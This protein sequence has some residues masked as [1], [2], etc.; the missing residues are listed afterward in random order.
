MQCNSELHCRWSI[1]APARRSLRDYAQAAE[2]LGY[3]YLVAPDH[4]LGVNPAADHGGRRV[5][6]TANP[7][8]DPFVLF[9]FLAGCTAAH[10]LRRRCADPG[11]APGGAGR[12]AGGQPRRAVRR[13]VPAWHRRR[14]ERGRVHRA[15]REFPQPRQ[16]V[17][18]TGAGDA[19]AMGGR[20]MSTSPASSTGSTMP[21][22]IRARP[23]AACRSGTAATPRRRSAARRSMAMG[24]CRWPIRRATRRWRRSTSCAG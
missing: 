22:S 5:G 10:R 4:V 9:G 6:T 13:A 8:H 20:R 2:G 7:Y 17:G 24:S 1:S 14:L 19:G 21:A 15:E 3:A 18:G 11:A 12:E 16:A 23:R